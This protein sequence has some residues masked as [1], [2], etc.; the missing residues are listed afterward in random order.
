MLFT[1]IFNDTASIPLI[2]KT[3]G[4]MFGQF[5][6]AAESMGLKHDFQYA[7]YANWK[8]HPIHSYGK[9]NVEHLKVVSNKYDP[10]GVFQ[11]KVPGGFKLPNL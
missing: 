4:N 11:K 5:Y 9:A 1:A 8:Q 10:R 2:Q 6:E 7:N 3:A